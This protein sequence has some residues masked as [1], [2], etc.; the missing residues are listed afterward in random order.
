MGGA[1]WTSGDERHDNAD[2]CYTRSTSRQ[3]ESGAPHSSA[4]KASTTHSL[5]PSRAGCVVV[6]GRLASALHNGGADRP[7]GLSRGCSRPQQPLRRRGI[8]GGRSG[9]PLRPTS[10]V[11]GA[12]HCRFP[13]DPVVAFPGSGVDLARVGRAVGRHVR[14]RSRQLVGRQ[15]VGV[16]PDRGGH[17]RPRGGDLLAEV[18]DGDPPLEQR[19]HAHRATA[20]K[21]RSSS[22]AG[23][24][25]MAPCPPCAGRIARGGAWWEGRFSARRP[26]AWRSCATAPVGPGGWSSWSCSWRC[27]GGRVW[28]RA[29]PA[30][31]SGTCAHGRRPGAR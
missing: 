31:P 30:S 24:E 13:P 9:A 26:G 12:Q 2:A 14:E 15:L 27:L 4:G 25:R 17:R 23:S 28:S 7:A 18:E 8:R 5:L 16:H 11:L 22:R 19:G 20:Q 6:P 3:P 29:T 21:C 10:D 1:S